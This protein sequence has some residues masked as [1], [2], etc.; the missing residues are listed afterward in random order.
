[1]SSSETERRGT[2]VQVDPSVATVGN[3]DSNIL[4]TVAVGVTNEGGLPV[5]VEVGASDGDSV[6]AVGDVEET[7]I[8]VLVVVTVAGEVDVVNPDLR[9]LLDADSITGLSKDLRD[10]DVTDDDVFGLNNTKADTVQS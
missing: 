5:V 1:M 7:I 9:S 2:R 3:S 4:I 8:V 6:R 10:D